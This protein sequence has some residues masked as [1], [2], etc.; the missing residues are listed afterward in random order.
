MIQ[1]P[2]P[3]KVEAFKAITK[4]PSGLLDELRHEVKTCRY[5]KE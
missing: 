2:A 1:G 5:E 3:D 4:L